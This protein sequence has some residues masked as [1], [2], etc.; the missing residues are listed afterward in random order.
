VDRQLLSEAELDDRLRRS[1]PVDRA[2]LDT[3]S[4][5]AALAS[6]RLWVESRGQERRLRNRRGAF[7]ARRL[8]VLGFVTAVVG[9]ASLVGIE[10]LTGGPE[11][12]GLP[13]AVS[14]AAAAELHRVASAAAGQATPAAGQWDYLALKVENEFNATAGKATVNYVLTS[15]IQEWNRSHGPTRQR[16][17]AD[18]FSL[19]T[20]QDRAA[21]RA[22]T[23]AFAQ[24]I[25][26]TAASWNGGHPR[27][28]SGPVSDHVSPG[29][30]T[31]KPPW[32]TSPPKDPRTL[33][34]DI[35]RQIIVPAPNP[36]HA[37]LEADF[38]AMLF[39]TLFNLLVNTTNPQ[40]RA[41]AYAA[42]AYVPGTHVLGD[43]KDQL[44]RAGT[45]ISF[46]L[47][48]SHGI[49]GGRSKIIV[50]PKTGDL[51]EVDVLSTKPSQGFPVGTVVQREIFLQSG[52]VDSDTALPGGRKQPYKPLTMRPD[53]YRSTSTTDRR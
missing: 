38:P 16:N 4:V 49:S 17:T 50:S 11:A 43:Q 34:T 41:T 53:T 48:G 22:N 13:L 10:T 46:A 19:L 12:G 36:A 27:T 3:E 23:A 1:N 44:G 47:K 18:S 40:L 30:S 7:R 39:G 45:A 35:R 14:P 31:Q 21:Y 15:T 8:T 52:I 32:G 2:K 6:M 51:L 20:P 29:A 25:D 26:E 28:F 33:I 37:G 42:L 9:V 5:L 24:Q